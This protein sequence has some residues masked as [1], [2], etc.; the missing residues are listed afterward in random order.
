MADD[1]PA[2]FGLFLNR[3]YSGMFYSE[4]CVGGRNWFNRDNES[5]EFNALCRLYVFVDKLGLVELR[6]T[7]LEY[8]IDCNTGEVLPEN[9]LI[10][11]YKNTNQG[12]PLRKQIVDNAFNHLVMGYNCVTKKGWKDRVETVCSGCDE[13]NGE[14]MEALGEHIGLEKDECDNCACKA[15]PQRA[16]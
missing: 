7:L 9:D 3:L 5:P 10:F 15:H 4:D 6:D 11:V 8:I 1:D 14:F 12:S 2:T 16:T 13:F